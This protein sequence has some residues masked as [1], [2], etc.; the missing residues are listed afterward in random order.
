MRK[1]HIALLLLVVTAIAVIAAN[2]LKFSTYETFKSAGSQPGKPFHVIGFLDKGKGVAYDPKT[3]PN[4]FSFYAK[5]KN[6]E[7]L[8]VVYI[9][10][11]PPRDIEKSEQLVMKGFVKGDA[12]YCSGIQ[13]KCPSK[14]KKDMEV[15]E[16]G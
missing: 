1:T 10:G 6:G 2:V 4:T 3:D 16:N 8:K 15:G 14:Y 5:D 13:M 9:N 7:E 12:F 11:A